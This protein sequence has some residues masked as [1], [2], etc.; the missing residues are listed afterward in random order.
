MLLPAVQI[1]TPPSLPGMAFPPLSPSVWSALESVDPVQL[2]RAQWDQL[3]PLL[4]A[5]IKFA[6][7]ECAPGCENDRTLA[8]SLIR[9]KPAPAVE[10]AIG[11]AVL[12]AYDI[13]LEDLPGDLILAAAKRA[14]RD[15][16]N[17]FR[18]GPS[19]LRGY[20]EPEFYAR[21]RRLNRLQRMAAKEAAVQ[22]IE[23]RISA[24]EYKFVGEQLAKLARDLGEKHP[25]PD[26]T[27]RRRIPEGPAHLPTLEEYLQMGVPRETAITAIAE[28][29]AIAA[30]S[31]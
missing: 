11:S 9:S 24:V 28:M 15:T 6:Q 7:A 25:T 30:A 2:T 3:G 27:S 29:R 23:R 16:S 14:V 4:P 13:A 19:E 21:R 17:R 20:V 5:A 18:P 8:I 31:A 1:A 26:A 22:D 12:M 10:Q